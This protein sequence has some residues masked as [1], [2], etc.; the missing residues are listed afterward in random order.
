M[1]II[2]FIDKEEKKTMNEEQIKDYVIN[3]IT[4]LSNYVHGVEVVECECEDGCAHCLLIKVNKLTEGKFFVNMKLNFSESSIRYMISLSQTA[5]PSSKET[6]PIAEGE[7][8]KSLYHL[9]GLLEEFHASI[10]LTSEHSLKKEA[11]VFSKRML[12]SDFFVDDRLSSK[13]DCLTFEMVLESNEEVFG[14]KEKVK[15]T[16]HP[17]WDYI[18][19]EKALCKIL[20]NGAVFFTMNGKIILLE[21]GDITYKNIHDVLE[22]IEMQR[23][24]KN[25]VDD[26][27]HEKWGNIGQAYQTESP[28]MNTA[29]YLLLKRAKGLLKQQECSFHVSKDRNVFAHFDKGVVA[30]IKYSEPADISAAIP[31]DIDFFAPSPTGNVDLSNSKPVI[32]IT[33]KEA[34]FTTEGSKVIRDLACYPKYNNLH[35]DE[36]NSAYLHKDLIERL[37]FV[38]DRG[39]I[40]NAF[41]HHIMFHDERTIKALMKMLLLLRGLSYELEPDDSYAV[42]SRDDDRGVG[43]FSVSE[44]TQGIVLKYQRRSP[45]PTEVKEIVNP[46]WNDIYHAATR[47]LW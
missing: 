15:E 8:K 39:R 43:R 6:Y 31:V 33:S 3:K 27:A 28:K 40:Y 45:Y 10:A 29:T 37:V 41:N 25:V 2:S 30:H 11:C 1:N 23:F 32:T 9:E 34:S 19:A 7:V 24:S 12:K 44:T 21:G 17:Q 20:P 47:I 5:T 14:K 13:S 38:D 42:F 4:S 18:I 26:N 36:L 16:S 35:E 22:D 46:S